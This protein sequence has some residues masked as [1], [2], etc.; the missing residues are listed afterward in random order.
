MATKYAMLNSIFS[1]LLIIAS[2]FVSLAA[3]DCF[4]RDEEGCLTCHQ[5]PGLVRHEKQDSFKVL[6]I[7]EKKYYN[8]THG[9]LRCRE[10]H[11]TIWKIPHTGESSIDCTTKCHQEDAEKILADKDYFSNYHSKEQSFIVKLTDK[12]SCSVCHQLYPHGE[13]EMVRSLLNMHT[14]FMYCEACHIKRSK[15]EPLAYAWHDTQN[16]EFSGEPFGTYYNP[17]T[18]RAQKGEHF[19]SRIAVFTTEKGKKRLLMIDAADTEKA[20]L[21]IEK[22]K[23]LKSDEKTFAY[24]HRDI[25]KKEISV[26]CNECHSADSILDYNKLGFEERK[27]KDLIYLNLKGLVT[28]YKVFYFPQMFGD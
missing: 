4:A 15:Y 2:C 19:I 25:D 13:N 24:F 9:K 28:K 1:I 23:N 14:G 20:K 7:D 16:A 12:S 11:T 18:K 21:F 26:A 8:S 22:G 27:T 3:K 5:Y 6:H 10:C 17:E